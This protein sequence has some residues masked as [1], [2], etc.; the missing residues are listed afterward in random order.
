VVTEP[1][2]LENDSPKQPTSWV[3]CCRHIQGYM[4][5][6]MKQYARP[7]SADSVVLWLQRSPSAFGSRPGT[8]FLCVP[9]PLHRISRTISW[10]ECQTFLRSFSPLCLL[11]LVACRKF[12]AFPKIVSLGLWIVLTCL[13]W[14]LPPKPLVITEYL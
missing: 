9:Y 1:K 7:A 12:I 8:S 14:S 4:V 13:G 10:V 2:Q 11:G 6:S 3:T 5:N